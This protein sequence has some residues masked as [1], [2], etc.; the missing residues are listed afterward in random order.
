MTMTVAVLA[1]IIADCIRKRARAKQLEDEAAVLKEEANTILMLY[2]DDGSI[3]DK[4]VGLD[5]VGKVTFVTKVTR[6]VDKDAFKLG[7]VN[8]GVSIG[9]IQTAENAATTSKSSTAPQF[10]PEKIR[11]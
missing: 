6:T 9:V 1:E 8:A 5:G 10:T 7:L 2:H 3:P 4:T 11:K